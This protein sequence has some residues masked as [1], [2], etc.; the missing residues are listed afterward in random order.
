MVCTHPVVPCVF[1][2]LDD[3]VRG[4]EVA[5]PRDAPACG[6]GEGVRSVA[7]ADMYATLEETEVL[8][9]GGVV[10]EA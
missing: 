5:V 6:C 2:H 4:E 1:W 10:V 3:E 8:G 7:Q 9:V